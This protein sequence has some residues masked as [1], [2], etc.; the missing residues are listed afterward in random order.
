MRTVVRQADYVERLAYTRSQ[1]AQAL[2]L[3][4]SS[5]I[6]RVLPFVETLEMPWGAKLIP[7]DELE[8]LLAERRRE[9]AKT[10]RPPTAKGRRPAVPAAVVDRIHR[11]RAEGATFRAIADDLTA[12]CVPTVHGGMRWWPSTVRAT[13]ERSERQSAR[14][15]PPTLRGR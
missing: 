7:V 13:L 4:R 14:P 3:S 12:D 2:G 1:A 6:R 15:M 9:A 11:A 8:R 5:F 10:R